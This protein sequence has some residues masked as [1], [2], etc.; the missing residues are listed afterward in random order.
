MDAE[1]HKK[2]K[3]STEKLE[4]A[5]LMKQ[6]LSA[7]KKHM[8]KTSIC[9]TKQMNTLE[10]FYRY[11]YDRYHRLQGQGSRHISSL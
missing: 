3:T 9:L 10:E 11:L 5:G 4:R 2:G 8:K 7:S 6:V 1:L